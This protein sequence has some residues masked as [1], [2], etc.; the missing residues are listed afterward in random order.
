MH[1]IKSRP[2]T[3]LLAREEDGY[4]MLAVIG[5]IAWSRMLVSAAVAATNS[6]Q[7]LI[8]RDIN[9]KRAYAAA[10][11]GIADYTYHLNNDSGYWT[12]CTGVPAR[13]TP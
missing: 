11:A 4:T 5:A 7:S 12:R 1:L 3:A 9:Q 8:R 10:Q 6:D 2:R 13:R